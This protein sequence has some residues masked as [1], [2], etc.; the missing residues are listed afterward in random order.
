[1]PPRV[2]QEPG[3]E[4]PRLERASPAGSPVVDVRR[5]PVPQLPCEERE[6]FSLIFYHGWQQQDVADLFE[7]NVRTVRRWWQSALVML[8]DVLKDTFTPEN[9]LLVCM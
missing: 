2:E 9:E 4:P 5:A 7:V 6:V 1:M 3:I 8:H